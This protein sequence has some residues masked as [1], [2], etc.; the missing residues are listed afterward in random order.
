MFLF[1]FQK[2]ADLRLNICKLLHGEEGL[3]KW[4]V[5]DLIKAKIVSSISFCLQVNLLSCDMDSWTSDWQT[6]LD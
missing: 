5:C 3:W 4:I 1:R 2:Q 6:Q